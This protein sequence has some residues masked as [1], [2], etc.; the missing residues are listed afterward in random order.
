MW[1][2][3]CCM[4]V[5]VPLACL[6]LVKV[7]RHQGLERWLSCGGEHW[8]LLQRLLV[9][10]PAPTWPI[11]TVCNSSSRGSDFL[12]WL[13][14]TLYTRASQT[15]MQQNTHERK[16]TYLES[17]QVWWT[18]EHCF[19]CLPPGPPGCLISVLHNVPSFLSA[20]GWHK[21]THFLAFFLFL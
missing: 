11:R 17:R 7:R 5:C 3:F 1:G 9:R 12:F 13:T 2:V 15:S 6:V 20:L 4:C 16:I 21:T 10:F 14:W 8:L 19:Q 18:G